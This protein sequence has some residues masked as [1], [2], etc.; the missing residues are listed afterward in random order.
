VIDTTARRDRRVD[1]TRDRLACLMSQARAEPH[2]VTT[3]R[4]PNQEWVDVSVDP[5]DLDPPPHE[6]WWRRG[7]AARLLSQWT[8][9]VA[10]DVGRRRLM[11]VV[12]VGGLVLA[13]LVAIGVAVSSSGT[14]YEPPPVLPVAA[15][16]ES[17]AKA[18]EPAI[19]VSVV[20]RVVSPGL[21]TVPEGAR[22]ADA[23]REA[24]GP[25]AGADLGALNLARRLADGEQ[26]YVG[27]PA[28]AGVDPAGAPPGQPGVADQVDLN[29]ASLAALDTLPGVGPVTAQ[30]IL[31]WRTA[32]GRFDS[33]N[34]LREIDGIGPSR[35]AKLKDHVVAR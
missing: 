14:E 11:A 29:S 5:P 15:A 2:E 18:P 34:Q 21:V 13:V 9:A 27:V 31:D 3:E 4:V 22:V 24:G 33:V 20:G 1:E 17:I 35:F 23:L 25:V 10:V 8:P 32:H 19:V 7:L 28:P 26:I 12:L 16:T 6:P 30:R